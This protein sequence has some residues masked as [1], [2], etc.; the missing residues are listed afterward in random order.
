MDYIKK[1]TKCNRE[2]PETIEY[3]KKH[4]NG[5][6]GLSSICKDCIRIY[7]KTY[8]KRFKYTVYAHINK[9]NGKMYI[10]QT[11]QKITY[12]WNNGNGYKQHSIFGKAIQKYGW[13][14]F[15]HEIIASNLTKEEAENFEKL[16]IRKLDTTNRSYG[17]NIHYN[18]NGVLK[19]N[20]KNKPHKRKIICDGIIFNSISECAKYYKVDRRTMNA[21][22]LGKMITPKEFINMGFNYYNGSTNKL[23]GENECYRKV[24][25]DN[26]FFESVA[27]CSEYYNVKYNTLQNWLKG[28][29]KMPQKYL[30]LGLKFY[31]ESNVA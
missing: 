8:K 28:R 7:N 11:K 1:C 6:N 26:M 24:F 5:K 4:K 29:N 3:F 16:L 19:D 25:C 12:R 14:N 22:L 30:D 13:D 21:W 15:E 9:T 31:E 27:E 20:S 23:K 10:G 18:E 2:L 17:Y